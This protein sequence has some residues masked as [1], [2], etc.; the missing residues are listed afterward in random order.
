[1]SGE[2]ARQ[3]S[4]EPT[5]EVEDF[6]KSH[7]QSR[8]R[9]FSSWVGSTSISRFPVMCSQPSCRRRPLSKLNTWS[10]PLQRLQATLPTISKLYRLKSFPFGH[11]P[12]P[13]ICLSLMLQKSPKETVPAAIVCV[14]A[15]TSCKIHLLTRT[16][17]RCERC[18]S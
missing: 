15:P 10:T 1:M 13:P 8:N 9:S 18:R 6:R 11:G 2:R 7:G 14:G 17:D 12:G 16:R 5:F 4:E 3:H